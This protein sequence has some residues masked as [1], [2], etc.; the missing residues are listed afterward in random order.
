MEALACHFL[1]QRDAALG[2]NIISL[3]H[4][5]EQWARESDRPTSLVICLEALALYY[6]LNGHPALSL[7]YLREVLQIERSSVGI[8][9]RA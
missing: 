9:A 7:A 5:L 3:L 2:Q 4:N 1:L 6:E 8:L